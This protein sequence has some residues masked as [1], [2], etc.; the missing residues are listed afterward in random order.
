MS[1]SI[2][3]PEA[4]QNR[5]IDYPLL[6]DA[7]SREVSPELTTMLRRTSRTHESYGELV[8]RKF[9]KSKIAIAGRIGR[10]WVVYLGDLCRVLLSV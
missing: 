6:P 7:E 1:E 8:W 3:F 5:S 10:H 2:N 9:R 4:E